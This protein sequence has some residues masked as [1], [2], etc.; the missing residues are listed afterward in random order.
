M[1]P[2]EP[3]IAVIG[4]MGPLA[5]AEFVNT[6][7]ERTSGEREQE[8]PRVVLWSDPTFPDRTSLLLDG[9]GDVLAGHLAH[10]VA[11]CDAMGAGQIVICCVTMHAVLPLLP[12]ELKTRIVSLVDVVLEAAI[13]RRRPHLLLSS[14]GTRRM[15]VFESHPLWDEAS[16]WLR[17]PDEQEHERL[18]EVIYAIKRRQDGLP[19]AVSLIRSLLRTHRLDTFVA[20]CTELHMVHKYWRRHTVVDCIDPLQIVADRIAS[21]VLVGRGRTA[22]AG[23]Q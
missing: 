12:A 9:R 19:Q 4:G 10:T 16:R 14:L 1:N 20:G 23:V 13:E 2:Q 8:M 5:S 6:I 21:P 11:Q 7:Y 18:H 3:V 15:G 17:W 22:E